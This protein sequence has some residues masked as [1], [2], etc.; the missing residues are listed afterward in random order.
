[1]TMVKT[2]LNNC[3]VR[4]ILVKSGLLLDYHTDLQP[5]RNEESAIVPLTKQ[6]LSALFGP[7]PCNVT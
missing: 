5:I 1:M 4:R 2:A 6:C 3:L 7:H